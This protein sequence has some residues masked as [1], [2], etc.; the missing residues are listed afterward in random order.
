MLLTF[1]NL[2]VPVS[3]P[4]TEGP[5]QVIQFMGIILDTNTMEARLPEDKV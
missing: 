1:K 5:S 4:K 3:L 2:N